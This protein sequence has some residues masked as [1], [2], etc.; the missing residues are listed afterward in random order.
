MHRFIY[1]SLFFTLLYSCRKNNTDEYQY[2][3]PYKR[4]DT[5]HRTEPAD[6]SAVIS[7]VTIDP[8]QIKPFQIDD[9]YF[10]VVASFSV[11]EYALAMQ[12]NLEKKGFKPGI[13]MINNDGWHKLAI[14]SYNTFSEA[15]EKLNYLKQGD[16]PFSDARIVVK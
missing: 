3:Q 5:V 14:G 12:Q 10:I 9:K 8:D 15:T 6:T 16:K 1:I 13:L 7:H 2:Y 4:I 11:E